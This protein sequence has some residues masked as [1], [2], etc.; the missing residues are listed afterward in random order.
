M[1]I[2]IKKKYI[3]SRIIKGSEVFQLD[4]NTTD[5]E[6]KYIHIHVPGYTEEYDEKLELAEKQVAA[7]SKT[8]KKKNVKSKKKLEE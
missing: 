3:N 1:A 2:R 7:Y 8:K 5:K 4:A 6:L